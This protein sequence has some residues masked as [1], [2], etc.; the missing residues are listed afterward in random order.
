MMHSLFRQLKD[1]LRWLFGDE[2]ATNY[3][4]QAINDVPDELRRE[5]IYLIGEDGFFL[6]AVL[7]CPC[8]CR[9][10][11]T[12][13]LVAPARPRWRVRFHA[14]GSLTM[15]PSIWRNVGCYSHFWIRRGRVLWAG[16]GE[17]PPHVGYQFHNEHGK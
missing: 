1:A 2:N 8:G 15:T 17:R 3:T 12:L 10:L 14:D 9:Q 4:A 16:R 11:I 5:V 13:N 7:L 6:Q